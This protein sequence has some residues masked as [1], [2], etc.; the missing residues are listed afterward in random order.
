M[1]WVRTKYTEEVQQLRKD[2]LELFLLMP[3]PVIET[4]NDSLGV[5]AG[6]RPD[7]CKSD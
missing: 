2:K 4:L 1:V 7:S 5:G 6:L 3:L